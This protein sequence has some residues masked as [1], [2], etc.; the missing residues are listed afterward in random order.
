MIEDEILPFTNNGANSQQPSEVYCPA[1]KAVH[2]R[3][4]EKY[5]CPFF[6]V[7]F[8]VFLQIVLPKWLCLF[9]IPG[10]RMLTKEEGLVLRTVRSKSVLQSYDVFE[11]NVSARVVCGKPEAGDS[12]L[13]TLILTGKQL[14]NSIMA[15]I[16]HILN[17]IPGR[18]ELMK[19]VQDT[20]DETFYS[21]GNPS[22][23][24]VTNAFSLA[25]VGAAFVRQKNP[26][27]SRSTLDASLSYHEEVFDTGIGRRHS[28]TDIGIAHNPFDSDDPRLQDWYGWY[29]IDGSCMVFHKDLQYSFAYIPTMF[30]GRPS[31]VRALRLLL[32]CIE[33]TQS[34]SKKL[35]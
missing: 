9:F 20:N 14:K 16:S 23:S 21:H 35:K 33:A 15:V 4:V 31:I 5:M 25:K 32:A 8:R 12:L 22:T 11:N 28:Y 6:P 2:N 18:K 7:F 19:I 27:V 10:D 34:Q 29:G 17:I 26:L 13:E 1:P 30:E 3:I 24:I